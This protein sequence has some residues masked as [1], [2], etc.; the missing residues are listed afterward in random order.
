MTTNLRPMR[1]CG[2]RAGVLVSEDVTSETLQD[3]RMT[4][5]AEGFTC[6]VTD[7]EFPG[8]REFHCG[9]RKQNTP[10]Q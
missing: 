3:R 5:V 1:L 9:A 8:I 10:S 4:L 6:W 2:F 7:E